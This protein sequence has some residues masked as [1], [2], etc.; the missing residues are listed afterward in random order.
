MPSR[1]K[2]NKIKKAINALAIREVMLPRAPAVILRRRAT[3]FSAWFMVAVR[4]SGI[5]IGR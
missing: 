2:K 1:K 3:P 4:K 5:E